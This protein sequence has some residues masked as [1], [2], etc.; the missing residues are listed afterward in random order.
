MNGEHQSTRRIPEGKPPKW[1]VLQ[2]HSHSCSYQV[3]SYKTWLFIF[4]RQIWFEIITQSRVPRVKMSQVAEEQQ[5]HDEGTHFLWLQSSTIWSQ[6]FS[7]W[8]DGW[9]DCS[10]VQPCENFATRDWYLLTFWES[11]ASVGPQLETALQV[12]L[13]ICQKNMMI[14]VGGGS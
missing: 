6:R 9:R 5:L 4:T 11:F 14:L 1:V 7:L 8:G 2:C 3:S 13:G 10:P 12:I